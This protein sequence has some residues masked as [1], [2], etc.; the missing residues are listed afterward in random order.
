MRYVDTLEKMPSSACTST[1]LGDDDD[2]VRG[3]AECRCVSKRWRMSIEDA[4][5]RD[6]PPMASISL[7]S[8]LRPGRLSFVLL[9]CRYH[10][11]EHGVVSAYDGVVSRAE[12]AGLRLREAVGASTLP[13]VN[14]SGTA[15]A[16]G[17]E[18]ASG[19]SNDLRTKI[20]T[21]D[22]NRDC[23]CYRVAL[24]RIVGEA[25]RN[26]AFSWCSSLGPEDSFLLEGCVGA[27]SL[28]QARWFSE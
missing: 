21:C 1:P 11:D 23:L 14:C 22:G 17:G 6:L 13:A 20:G 27:S 15:G 16:G 8:L 4:I 12:A 26:P 10:H 3:G 7:A 5:G 19:S 18:P 25:L 9:S 28:L 2:A 24:K